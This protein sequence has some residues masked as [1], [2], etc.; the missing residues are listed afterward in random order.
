MKCA[1]MAENDSVLKAK[2]QHF[3]KVMGTIS[4]VDRQSQ[5]CNPVLSYF[6]NTILQYG[7]DSDN[8]S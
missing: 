5:I 7:I 8:L 2:F 3:H 6:R 1:G 4:M